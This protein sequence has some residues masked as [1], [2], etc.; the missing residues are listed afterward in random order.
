M[1]YIFG[2]SHANTNF[3][4][5]G[6]PH[7]N[8][9]KNAIT[10]HRVG[11]DRKIIGL[12]E[13]RQTA[14]DIY[15]FCNGEIDCRCHVARQIALGREKEEIIGKLVGDYVKAIRRNV[16]RHRVIILSCVTPPMSRARYEA[17]HG[18]ITHEFPFVGTDAERADYSRIMNRMLEAACR[19]AGFIFMDYYGDYTDEAGMLRYDLSDEVCHIRQNGKILEML[20]QLVA[21]LPPVAPQNNGWRSFF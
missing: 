13:V 18:P 17:K 10:M 4:N 15:V 1:I 8:F 19:Q 14:E 5:L 12:S 16:R 11:R 3:A 9:Y 6:L 20:Q 2:D 7:R 21:N